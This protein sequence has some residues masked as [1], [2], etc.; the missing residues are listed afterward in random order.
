MRAYFEFDTSVIYVVCEKYRN[1]VR[2]IICHA[3][4]K[5]HLFFTKFL[6]TLKIKQ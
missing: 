2:L 3:L 5:Y 6:G 1:F 4:K